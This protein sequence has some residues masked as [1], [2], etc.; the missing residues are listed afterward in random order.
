[1]L[2]RVKND[3]D[4]RVDELY[5]SSCGGGNNLWPHDFK[6]GRAPVELWEFNNLFAKEVRTVLSSLRSSVDHDSG[7]LSDISSNG[8]TFFKDY[9]EPQSYFPYYLLIYN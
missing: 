7:C 9:Q 1:M 4:C 8:Q 6:M 2:N 5:I 3:D